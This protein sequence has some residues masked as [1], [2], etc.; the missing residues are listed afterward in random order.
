MFFTFCDRQ[1]CQYRE[2]VYVKNACTHPSCCQ[3]V[4]NCAVFVCLWTFSFITV[5]LFSQV[6]GASAQNTCSIKLPEL[7]LI[8]SANT[9]SVPIRWGL[10]PPC[11]LQVAAKNGKTY[12]SAYCKWLRTTISLLLVCSVSNEYLTLHLLRCDQLNASILPY[13][14]GQKSRMW[15][16]WW[17]LLSHFLCKS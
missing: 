2:Y 4:N 15:W 6:G 3:L 17:H 7:V 16:G 12:G 14:H 8:T 9:F 1:I 11:N 10:Q 13:S 5:A